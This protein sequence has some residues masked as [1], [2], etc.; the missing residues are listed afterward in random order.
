[1]SGRSFTFADVRARR[2]EILPEVPRAKVR[3]FLSFAA[4]AYEKVQLQVVAAIV[5]DDLPAL[6][7]VADT[8]LAALRRGR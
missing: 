3:G 4:P 8:E 7:A 2:Q 5:A 6:K 1:M